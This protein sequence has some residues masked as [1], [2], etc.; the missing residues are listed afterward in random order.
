MATGRD[1][2]EEPGAIDTATLFEGDPFEAMKRA[3]SDVMALCDQLEN[4]ADSLPDNVDRQTC[5]HAARTLWPLVRSV[6]SFEETVLFPLVEEKFAG[7][8]G[9]SQTIER[10]KHEHFDDECYAEELTDSLLRLGAGDQGLNPEATGY[11]LRGFFEAMRR[12]IAFEEEHLLGPAMAE[13]EKR[14]L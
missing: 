6:H 7:R 12:H 11:M 2:K 13:T 14:A 8:E 5:V 3:H 9:L 4:I 10:L 1:S